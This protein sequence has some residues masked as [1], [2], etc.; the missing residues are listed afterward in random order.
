M[1]PSM[2]GSAALMLYISYAGGP[3]L[4]VVPDTKPLPAAGQPAQCL[5][6]DAACPQPAGT[7]PLPD[8]PHRLPNR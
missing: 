6:V 5:A 1:R 8:D 7:P 3:A 2:M 4:V